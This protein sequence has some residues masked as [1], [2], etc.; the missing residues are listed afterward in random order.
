[1]AWESTTAGAYPWSELSLF[2]G[3]VDIRVNVT[4]LLDKRGHE[5]FIR[6]RTSKRC[7][8]YV[9][10]QYDEGSAYCPLCDGY[11]Y[12]Y[13]DHRYKVRRRPAFG[14]FGLNPKKPT[15]LG[16][17]IIG[18]N[19]FYFKHDNPISEADRVIEVTIDENGL[20]EK[21]YRIERIH[22]IKYVH[23]FRDQ[24]GRIEYWV[25]LTRERVMGK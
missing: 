21:P 16:D 15:D 17:L 22:D 7:S 13:L 19:V 8:C 9:D 18:D 6:K 2:S 11:G 3:E 20:A 24:K 1:M 12:Y 4:A 25:A 5:V 10:R 23:A 14:T